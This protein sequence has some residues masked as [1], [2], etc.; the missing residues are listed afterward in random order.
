MHNAKEMKLE[1][2]RE[3]TRED[4]EEISRYIRGS[5]GGQQRRRKKEASRPR[6]REQYI[7]KIR[8]FLRDV[9][10]IRNANKFRNNGNGAQLMCGSVLCEVICSPLAIADDGLGPFNFRASSISRQRII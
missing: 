6:N 10:G 4:Q 2:G 9:L 7:G 1:E 5:K 3:P 8:F